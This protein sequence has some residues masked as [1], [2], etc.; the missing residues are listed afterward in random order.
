M[1]RLQQ[2]LDRQEIAD[3]IHRLARAID[4]CDAALIADCYHP[5]ATDDHGLLKGSIDEFIAGVIPMLQSMLH[6]QHNITNLL[7]T[8]KGPD[9]A[10]SEAYFIAQH[11]LADGQEMFAAGRY[12]DRFTRR[13]GAWKIAHREAVYD[14]T[15]AVPSS[16]A[17]GTEPMLSLLRRG[18]RG[19][20]DPSYRHLAGG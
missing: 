2:L 5:D 3:V 10:R 20:G 18:E 13:D 12:L 15:M 8:F 9:E 7:V 14:W 1:D 6:T 11:S 19:P 16:G 17:W 4:R